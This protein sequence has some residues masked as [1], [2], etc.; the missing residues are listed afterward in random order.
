[1]CRMPSCK[2]AGISR[3]LLNGTY[4]SKGNPQDCA[5][6]DVCDAYSRKVR[7]CRKVLLDILTDWPCCCPPGQRR[8]S[9]RHHTRTLVARGH[10]EQRA[11]SDKRDTDREIG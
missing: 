11:E 6:G 10:T 2:N 3:L 4:L 1:M 8:C 9:G 7:K 5:A